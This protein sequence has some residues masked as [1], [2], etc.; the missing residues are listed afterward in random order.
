M[1]RNRWQHTK[2]KVCEVLKIG[3]FKKKQPR[4][5]K[6]LKRPHQGSLTIVEAHWGFMNGTQKGSLVSKC[7][8]HDST[9]NIAA[10]WGLNLF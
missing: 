8:H 5:L 3:Q 2:I 4:G 9:K 7:T 6:R 10:H 1:A